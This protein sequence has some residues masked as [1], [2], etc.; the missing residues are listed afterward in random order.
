M[1]YGPRGIIPLWLD[2]YLLHFVA[3]LSSPIFVFDAAA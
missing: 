2:R 1:F 3:D